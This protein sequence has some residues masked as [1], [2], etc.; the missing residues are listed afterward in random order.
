M[1]NEI[2]EEVLEF[3]NA[4]SEDEKEFLKKDEVIAEIN[5]YFADK[6]AK[7]KNNIPGCIYKAI[8]GNVINFK[9]LF[10]VSDKTGLTFKKNR[11]R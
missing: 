5:T 4:N 9:E 8:I 1:L 3:V 10:G 2:V 7:P 6:S 11:S